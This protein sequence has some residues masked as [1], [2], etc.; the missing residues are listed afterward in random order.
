MK[1]S[2]AKVC[3]VLL[4]R[5]ERDARKSRFAVGLRYTRA[6]AR[7][8]ARSSASHEHKFGAD[9][10]IHMV[11]LWTTPCLILILSTTRQLTAAYT[12]QVLP[13][14]LQSRTP[15]PLNPSLAKTIPDILS[16]WLLHIPMSQFPAAISMCLY[17]HACGHLTLS[18]VRCRPPGRRIC[19]SAADV[20]TGFSYD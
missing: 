16:H 5:G 9:W 13:S 10:T 3:T 12:P 6:T 2:R 4:S 8:P 15:C 20:H 1:W 11:A 18:S 14:Q 19:S 17:I 7:P